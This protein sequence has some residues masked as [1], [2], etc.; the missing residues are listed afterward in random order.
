VSFSRVNDIKFKHLS[1]ADWIGMFAPSDNDTSQP[2]AYQYAQAQPSD[3]E[4]ETQDGYV[5]FIVPPTS[6]SFVFKYMRNDHHVLAT[7]DQIPVYIPCP[8]NCSSHGDCSLGHC[9]CD[10]GWTSA[11]CSQ[12]DV[13]CDV[14]VDQEA[15][16]GEPV[17]VRFEMGVGVGSGADF[18]GLYAADSGSNNEM[19]FDWQHANTTLTPPNLVEGSVSLTAGAPGSYVVRY[20]NAYTQKTV[21]E[22][23]QI[24]AFPPC[25]LS[26]SDRG[27]CARGQCDCGDNWLGPDCKRQKGDVMLTVPP[28][29]VLAKAM[30]EMTNYTVTLYRPEGWH[31]DGD[32]VGLFPGEGSNVGVANVISYKAC[33]P[34]EDTL[35][36]TFGISSLTPPGK[37]RMWYVSGTGY[38]T[39]AQSDVFEIVPD[40]G[41]GSYDLIDEKCNCPSDKQGRRCEAD[42]CCYE[43]TPTTTRGHPQEEITVS[44]SRPKKSGHNSDII[45][46]FKHDAAD[47]SAP[48]AFQFADGGDTD[49]G[50]ITLSLPPV[51]ETFAL[52]YVSSDGWTSRHEGPNVFVTLPCDPADCSGHGVCI[53]GKCT[54]SSGWGG[55]K[56]SVTVPSS[57][58]LA[59][60]SPGAVP[61]STVF[62]FRWGRPSDKGTRGDY[63][64]IFRRLE[65]SAKPYA[66]VYV[67]MS[68]ESFEGTLTLTAPTIPGT[69]QL[70]WISAESKEPIITSAEF[71]VQ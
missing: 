17:D 39:V 36:M 67:P 47:F 46:L 38:A 51:E 1:D 49:G 53:Q 12:G 7:T 30:L 62:S 23:A 8:N 13:A 10:P 54:C 41:P 34:Q 5:T 18:V 15:T 52:H 60:E 35:E 48:F 9:T 50:S 19:L 25:P 14:R 22:S 66:F 44:W 56:C 32:F 42:T 26:C 37:Y 61:V 71:D 16:V 2:F 70:R 55:S 59:V 21:C 45:G 31:N 64:G 3:D 27:T 65:S 4:D 43:M 11:D 68:K 57:L 20:V 6:G 63:I 29:V 69:Y 33:P 58:Q 40:C 24:E 28:R